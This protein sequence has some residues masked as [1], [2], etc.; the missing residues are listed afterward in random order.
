MKHF[1]IFALASLSLA[2]GGCRNGNEDIVQSTYIHKYGVPVAK[3]DWDAGGK[4]GKIISLKTDGVTVAKGYVDGVLNGETTYSFSN[5][6]TVQFVEVY[7]KGELTAKRENYASGVPMCEQLFREDVLVKQTRWYEAGTPTAIETYQ[8]VFLANGEYRTLDNEVEAR[9]QNGEGTRICRSGEGGLISKDTFHAG[10]MVERITYFQNSDPSTL[11]SYQMGK[12]HGTRLTYLPGGL[13]C[14]L[15]QW[16]HGE[17]QGTTVVYQNG[18]KYAEVPYIAGKKHGVEVRFR[19]GEQRVEEITWV[20]GEQ[21]GKRTLY[22]EG[23][24]KT[25]WYH[26]GELVSRTLFER[27]NVPH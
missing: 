19:D 12:I 16:V 17:Q 8:G 25:Q 21:H 24:A 14:T 10:D 18:E 27:M 15:E 5:S 11:A 26:H 6:S 7:E 13:P 23:G 3:S 9:V 2:L 20:E 22:A 4:T 1:T